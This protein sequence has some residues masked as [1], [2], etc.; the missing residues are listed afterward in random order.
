MQCDVMG[1]DMGNVKQKDPTGWFFYS[2]RDILVWSGLVWC[3]GGRRG[4]FCD[5]EGLTIGG[6]VEGGA[7]K[8]K[9]SAGRGQYLRTSLLGRLVRFITMRDMYACDEIL[10]GMEAE[11]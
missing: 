10:C 6:G 5:T 2:R 7:G 3:A 8:E 11:G 4:F 1:G 9:N